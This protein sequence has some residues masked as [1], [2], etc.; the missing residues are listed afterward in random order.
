MP[1]GWQLLSGPTAARYA[2]TNGRLER[3]KPKSLGRALRLKGEG[4]PLTQ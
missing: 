1:L 3:Q 4:L 2:H